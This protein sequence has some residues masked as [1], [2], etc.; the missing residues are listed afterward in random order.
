MPAPQ[1]RI[2]RDDE[3][4]AKDDE[5]KAKEAAAT[6]A[7]LGDVAARYLEFIPHKE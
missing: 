1:I 7:L 2:P 3:D 6:A 5:D 4:K